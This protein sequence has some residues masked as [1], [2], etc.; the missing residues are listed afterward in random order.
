MTDSEWAKWPLRKI[1]RACAVDEGLVRKVHKEL[2]ADCPQ[3]E[4]PTVREITTSDGRSYDIDTT[5]IGTKPLEVRASSEPS[6][7][8]DV[9]PRSPNAGLPRP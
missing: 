1:A 3:F 5:N 9:R 8:V 4:K 6:L 7:V 2:T